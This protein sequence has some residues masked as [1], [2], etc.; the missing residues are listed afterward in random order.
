M[1]PLTTCRTCLRKAELVKRGQCKECSDHTDI[2]LR[3]LGGK[4][5]PS[6]LRG[7]SLGYHRGLRD[8]STP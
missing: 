8:D 2:R 6:D 5:L 1:G 7:G 4:E 3:L